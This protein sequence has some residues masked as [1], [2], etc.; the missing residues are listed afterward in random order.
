MAMFL[1]LAAFSDS[2]YGWPEGRKGAFSFV[3]NSQ[4]YV[5]HGQPMPLIQ[6]CKNTQCK[7]GP[8]QRFDF[9]S[10]L[11]SGVSP[12]SV[13]H[14]PEERDYWTQICHGPAHRLGRQGFKIGVC[15]A[16]LGDCAYTF[17]GLWEF[18]YAVHELNLETMVWRRLESQNG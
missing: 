9:P 14:E 8:L 6:G 13:N 4:F 1:S 3:H 16:V 18:G 11:W 2:V 17:G 15:C 7:L 12:V 10:A 5:C